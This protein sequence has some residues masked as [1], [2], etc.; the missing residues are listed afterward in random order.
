MINIRFLRVLAFLLVANSAYAQEP[1]SDE[2]PPAL[3]D[4]AMVIQITTKV[5]ENSQELWNAFNSKIAIPG[6]PVGIKLVGDN[7]IITVQF[8]P[9]LQQGKYVLRTQSEIIINVPEK[10]MSYKTNTHSIPMN[11]G[12]PILYLPLGP[13]SA[14]D[15]P[16]IELLL[17]MYRYGEEPVPEKTAESGAKPVV[18]EEPVQPSAQ[19]AKP[20][21][22]EAVP[23]QPARTPGQNR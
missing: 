3:R 20:E 11:L 22:K 6:R 17:T 9:Y 18:P 16:H 14:A 23:A 19:G 7:L 12:E 15:T 10:G 5:E 21:T 8:T 2:L 13:K 4:K 1:R